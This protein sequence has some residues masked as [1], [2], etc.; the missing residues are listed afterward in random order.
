MPNALRFASRTRLLIASIAALFAISIFVHQMYFATGVKAASSTIVISQV[1]GGGGATTGTPT[2][3]N[4]YVELFN[5]SASSVSLNGYSLQYGS[6]T[7]TF[8]SSASNLYAFPSG[9]TIPA[10]RYLLVKL[11]SAG[12]VGADFTADLTS[13]NL[14]MAAGSGK[15]ALVNNTTALGC[16]ATA[17]P[18]ALPDSRIVDVV[19]Y[20]ASNNG[21]GGTTVNNGTGLTNQQGGVRKVGGLSRHR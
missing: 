21:E 6:S 10:G 5:L 14:S 3:K 20:G 4:D 8:A 11:G 15:V 9:T 1:Y 17:T 2:Y 12:T 19:A 7:G 13:G 16:G 18:C